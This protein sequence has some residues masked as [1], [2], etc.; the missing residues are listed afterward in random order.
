MALPVMRPWLP[1][2]AHGGKA[3]GRCFSRMH[4]ARDGH[5]AGILLAAHSVC[6]ARRLLVRLQG[7][8]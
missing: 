4:S 3:K 1:M 7:C 6:V 5:D 8:L 2:T